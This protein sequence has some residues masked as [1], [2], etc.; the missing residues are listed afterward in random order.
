KI[1]AGLRI[2]RL[3]AR[4]GSFRVFRDPLSRTAEEE[5][6]GRSGELFSMPAIRSLRVRIDRKYRTL[7]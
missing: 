2:T 4:P 3:R 5:Y 6:L 1:P 7:L